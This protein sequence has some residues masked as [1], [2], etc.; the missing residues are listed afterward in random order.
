MEQSAF[1]LAE[2][3]VIY[4]PILCFG[5]FD[6]CLWSWIL[7]CQAKNALQSS[8]ILLQSEYKLSEFREIKA[9]HY[10]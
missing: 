7:F 9:M 3:W 6:Y 8:S 5:L 10:F 4:V 2:D 1:I